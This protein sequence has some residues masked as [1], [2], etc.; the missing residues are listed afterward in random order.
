MTLHGF[1]PFRCAVLWGGI[2][3]RYRKA[4]CSRRTT[5]AGNAMQERSKSAADR[6]SGT[7]IVDADRSVNDRTPQREEPPKDVIKHK[8]ACPLHDER[9]RAK[10]YRD[11]FIVPVY[12]LTRLVS[13]P[14]P[15]TYGKGTPPA[16][17]NQ[18]GQMHLETLGLGTITAHRTQ[19][20]VST[21][22]W[23]KSSNVPLRILHDSGYSRIGT[24]NS[25]A[26]KFVA[27]NAHSMCC[28]RCGSTFG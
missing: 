2:R 19:T 26:R 18:M 22:Q 15:H 13:Q 5:N 12:L 27:L 10:G 4:S 23:G 11:I 21:T 28:Q 14:S 9:R 17:A 7:P 16:V 25:A 20:V 3:T 24:R 8:T 6:W 1:L